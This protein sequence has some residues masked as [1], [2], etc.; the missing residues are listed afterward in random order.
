MHPLDPQTIDFDPPC[1][2][3]G[4]AFADVEALVDEED[5]LFFG[6]WMWLPRERKKKIYLARS[7]GVYNGGRQYVASV[8]LHVEILTRA[9]GPP[10]TRDRVICDHLNGDSLDCRRQNLRWVTK[11]QNNQNRFGRDAYQARLL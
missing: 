6:R 8:Y 7:S 11:R 1:R 9:E 4:G 2:I 3:Y 10:P 5:Y